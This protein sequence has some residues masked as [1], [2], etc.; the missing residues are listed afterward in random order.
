MTA[1]DTASVSLFD[2]VIE[3]GDLPL[4]DAVKG[5]VDLRGVAQVAIDS[6]RIVG[7]GKSGLYLERCAGRVERTAISRAADYGLYSVQ[8]TGLSIT[9]NTVAD[10]ANGGILVHRW[11]AGEDG[12]IVAGNR[13][14]RIAARSGGTG[15]YGNG[16][17]VFRADT[18]VV[19]GNVVSD[20]AFSAIRANSA[21]TIQISGNSCMR[22]GE[23]A[24]YAEFAFQGAVID[25]NIVDG[26]ANEA[27]RQW[28]AETLQIAPSRV[29]LLR[30]QTSRRKQWQVQASRAV[31]E[32]WLSQLPL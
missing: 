25:G 23:T 15:Q 32:A 21:S 10:C 7:S 16:I 3:G 14:S 17:N 24:I 4:G 30:G 19:S 12:T 18:V 9:G 28:L 22:S 5:L 29:T 31:I 27:L 13:V 26:A 8:A 11:E 2:L 6:C 20:C 1:T